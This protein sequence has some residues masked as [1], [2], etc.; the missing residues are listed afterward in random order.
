MLIRTKFMRK[1]VSTDE[2]PLCPVCSM[3]VD[4]ELKSAYKGKTYCLCSQEHK[5]MF[6]KSTAKFAITNKDQ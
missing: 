2:H 6:D 3:D 4:R 5:A 1:R